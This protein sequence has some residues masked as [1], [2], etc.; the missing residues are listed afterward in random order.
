LSIKITVKA[1]LWGPDDGLGVEAVPYLKTIR[2]DK[3]KETSKKRLGKNS[4]A[5]MQ[6]DVTQKGKK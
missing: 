2:K 6:W 3:K 5:W 1:K 4:S